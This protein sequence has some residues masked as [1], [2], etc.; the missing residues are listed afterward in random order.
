MNPDG[1]SDV[2]HK[3]QNKAQKGNNT[4][5]CKKT[6]NAINADIAKE[7]NDRILLKNHFQL[8]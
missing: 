8:N 1:I 7:C 5:I 2:M 4:K 3:I 6:E